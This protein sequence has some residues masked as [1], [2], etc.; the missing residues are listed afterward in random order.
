VIAMVKVGK[1]EKNRP[2]NQNIALDLKNASDTG[3]L[4]V[5]VFAQ[6]SGLGRV[7]GA[8]LWRP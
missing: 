2:F 5:V 4:R 7:V 1:L 6:E 3:N 8:A